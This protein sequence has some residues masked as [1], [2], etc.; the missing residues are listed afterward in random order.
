MARAIDMLTGRHAAAAPARQTRAAPHGR[1]PLAEDPR[2]TAAARR[3]PHC[4]RHAELVSIA[5]TAMVFLLDLILPRGVAPA[6]GYCVC[7]VLASASPWRGF[8][9]SMT[10]IC[11]ILTLVG[12]ALE[13]PSEVTPW[14]P[15]L[16][17]AMVVGVIWLT[18]GLSAMRE[19]AWRSLEARAAQVARANEEL[20]AFA[21]AVAHDLRS[22]LASISGTARLLERAPDALPLERRRELLEIVSRSADEMRCLIDRALAYA[23]SGAAELYKTACDSGAAA[24]RAL[25]N[26]EAHLGPDA[27]RVMIAADLPTVRADEDLLVRLFQNLLENAVKYRGPAPLEV[28]VEAR[29]SDR[30]WVFSV[31]DN[32]L[33]IDPRESERVFLPFARGRG[34]VGAGAGVGLATCRKIVERHGGRIWI[35]P[36]VRSGTR[37][38]FA[39][40]ARERA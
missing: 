32:G 17:R 35:D 13:P 25:R 28:R 7:V 3:R 31:T 20:D 9:L 40:P 27:G 23:R 36:N 21:S 18:A 5:L 16:N 14:M 19:R 6:I 1:N 29:R 10:I 39:L 34:A 24:R 11:S 26:L 30:D 15:A 12:M 22:P 8:L 33:G 37:I 38:C 2:E 4:V